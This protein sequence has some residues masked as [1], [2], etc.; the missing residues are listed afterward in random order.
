MVENRE[1]TPAATSPVA[2]VIE[3]QVAEVTTEPTRASNDPRARRHQARGNQQAQKSVEKVAPSQIPTLGLYT[4]GSLIRHVYGDDC[5]ILID[6]FG[7]VTTFNRAL[8]KFTEQYEQS[9]GTPSTPQEKRPVT[10]DVELPSQKPTAEAEPAEVLALTPPESSAVRVGNDPRERRRLAKLAV[11][12]AKEVNQPS[13]TAAVVEEKPT[14]VIVEANVETESAQQ[15]AL[16]LST[17]DVVATENTV[18]AIPS[19]DVDAEVAES[20]DE[21]NESSTDLESEDDA[22]LDKDKSARPR[23]PRGRPP[24]KNIVGSE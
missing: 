9:Q 24:K 3:V 19:V 14:E 23:R 15:P 7:L 2:E 10:R 12:Q 1:I 16:E 4:L 18:E 13:T 8:I 20:V 6:Q 11:E 22:A 21:T 17:P 5:N